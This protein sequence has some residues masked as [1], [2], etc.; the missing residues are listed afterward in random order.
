MNE[1][2]NLKA[3]CFQLYWFIA[4]WSTA[5]GLLRHSQQLEG[6]KTGKQTSTTFMNRN[7]EGSPLFSPS[8]EGQQSSP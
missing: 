5:Q 1:I 7:P 2:L 3:I 8:C 6:E 4:W